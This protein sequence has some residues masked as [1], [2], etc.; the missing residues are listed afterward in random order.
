MPTDYL[1]VRINQIDD[2]Q[3]QLDVH[4]DQLAYSMDSCNTIS[5]S[6]DELKAS[7]KQLEESLE[8]LQTSIRP[9]LDAYAERPKQK[10]LWEI[11]EPN[12]IGIDFSYKI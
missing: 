11:F 10:W 6:M 3:Y 12:D 8:K 4:S 5:C 7:V 2:L 9:V 1:K